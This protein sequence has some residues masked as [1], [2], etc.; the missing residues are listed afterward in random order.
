MNLAQ[1]TKKKYEAFLK[2][3]LTKIKKFQNS[4]TGSSS[5]ESAEIS[6][7]V[8]RAPEPVVKTA[9]YTLR[10]LPMWGNKVAESKISFMWPKKS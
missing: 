8:R 6:A 7:P 2:T 9:K 4:L 10:K 1:D 3:Q 5:S